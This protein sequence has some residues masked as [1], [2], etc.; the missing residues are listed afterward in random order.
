MK[1]V[2]LEN[3]EKLE[4]ILIKIERIP[5]EKRNPIIVDMEWLAIKLREAYIIGVYNF[6]SKLA[7]EHSIIEK[8]QKAEI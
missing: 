5:K 7:D 6:F 4:L 8:N 1:G 3:A 2:I